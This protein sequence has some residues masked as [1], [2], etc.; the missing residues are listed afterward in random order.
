MTKYYFS[1]FLFMLLIINN[2]FLN[3]KFVKEKFE[4]KFINKIVDKIYVI[5]MDKDINR[6]KILDKKMKKLG[7]EYKRIPGVD[8]KKKYSKYK[9]K[10]KLRPGQLGCLLSHINVIKDAIKNNYNNILV[11][12]D[13]IVFHKNFHMEFVKKYKK[14]IKREKKF[15]LIYLGCSQSMGGNGKWNNTLMED[16]YYINYETDGTFGMLINK[17]I[18]LKIIEVNKN[19]EIPIDTSLSKNILATKKYKCFTLYPH[20]ITSNV[21]ELSNTD[22][23]MRNLREYLTSNKLKYEDYDFT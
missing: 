11:L 18:F 5:N 22:N 15:D 19:M 13:D 21:D 20:L 4:S 16:E 23:R 14:L 6:M 1:I 3:K 12:E 8:G 17:N 9:N 2:F 7:L 10:T